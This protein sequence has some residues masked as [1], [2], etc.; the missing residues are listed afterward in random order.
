MIRSVNTANSKNLVLHFSRSLILF[1][2]LNDNHSIDFTS[3][4]TPKVSKKIKTIR[5]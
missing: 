2:F 3:K 1:L 4:T 5:R